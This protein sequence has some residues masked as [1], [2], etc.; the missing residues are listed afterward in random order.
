[1]KKEYD[2]YEIKKYV[3][4][5]GPCSGKSETLKALQERGFY[6]VNEAAREVIRTEKL[7]N[8][9]F[10]PS[11]D[12]IKFQ[13]KV[14]KTQ[15]EWEIVPSEVRKYHK[16]LFVD[17]GILD[18]IAFL[19]ADNTA[20]FHELEKAAKEANYSKIFYLD[21][22]EN[23]TSEENR[24]ETEEEAKKVHKIIGEVYSDYGY[25]LI[26]VPEMSIEERVEMIIKEIGYD[27]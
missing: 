12:I 7:K 1:M 27:N 13:E 25:G 14:L 18:G 19:K 2:E 4:T 26:R 5:G 16:E 11:Y 23:Y 10:R 6:C 20:I 9:N 8:K 22:L 15:I 17:R 21:I 3:L 24:F